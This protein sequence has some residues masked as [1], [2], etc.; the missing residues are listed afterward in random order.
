MEQLIQQVIAVLAE[1]GRELGDTSESVANYARG[2]AIYLS[3]LTDDPGFALAVRAEQDNVL[4]YAG[5]A[6]VD[7]ADAADARIKGLLEGVLSVAAGVIK[8]LLG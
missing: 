6:L 1:S 3:T 5:I 7:E 4:L 8:G 2:R